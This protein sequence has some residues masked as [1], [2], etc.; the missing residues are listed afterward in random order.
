MIPI[1][2][3]SNL[4]SGEI[5]KKGEMKARKCCCQKEF[6]PHNHRA[7]QER[8]WRTTSL[9]VTVGTQSTHLETIEKSRLRAIWPKR[10]GKWKQTSADDGALR[11]DADRG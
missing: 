2:V 6:L 11:V 3:G 1:C 7:R 9:V 10:E 8:D 4:N 5:R